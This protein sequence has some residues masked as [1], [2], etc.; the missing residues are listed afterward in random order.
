MA[1]ISLVE[2]LTIVS[3]LETG[4]LPFVTRETVF[5]VTDAFR[6]SR[7][8]LNDAAIGVLNL[9]LARTDVEGQTLR[10]EAYQQR[11]RFV[12]TLTDANKRAQARKIGGSNV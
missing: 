6:R 12:V 5:D 8:P 4:K 2:A 7:T 9:S 10:M 1:R 11:V 3:D